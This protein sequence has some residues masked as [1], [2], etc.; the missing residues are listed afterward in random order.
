MVFLFGDCLIRRSGIIIIGIGSATTE[1]SGFRITATKMASTR[2]TARYTAV[3]GIDIS[4][5]SNTFG[6]LGARRDVGAFVL[7]TKGAGIILAG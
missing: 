1:V 4:R 3:E 6:S 2:S 7:A 5:S